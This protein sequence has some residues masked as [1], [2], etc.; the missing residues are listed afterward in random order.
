MLFFAGESVMSINI[1]FII[2]PIDTLNPKKDSTIAMMEAAQKSGWQCFVMQTK[3]LFSLQGESMALMQAI[4]IDLTKSPWY[5][6]EA[7]KT[8]LL[9]FCQVL[10]MRKDPPFNL[11][12]IYATYLLEQAERAGTL[13]VNKPQS[14]RDVNEKCFILNFPDCIPPTVVTAHKKAIHAFWQ[15]HHDIII[16]PL[17]GMG[18]SGVFRLR[19]GDGNFS[20]IVELLTDQESTPVMVQRYIPEITVGDKRILL[21]EGEPVP[22]V[23]ARIPKSG[24]V[25]ANLAAGGTGQV[26]PLTEHDYELCQR[27]APVLKEKGL[28]FVGLDVI[29][30]YI[31]EINVTSPTCIREINQ[32]ADTQIHEDLIAA[33]AK[34]L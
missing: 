5:Q 10:M 13:V 25:R 2:D 20:G 4:R 30:D 33:I 8:E 21:I 3:D 28:L 31:T 15:E 6:L 11:K 12:Y 34:R 9:S 22:Y 1:G 18:G 17:D 23:L 7:S 16:K 26:R 19:S 24:E 27:V 32:G 29:G 14:L